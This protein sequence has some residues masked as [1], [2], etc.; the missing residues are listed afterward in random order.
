M[1]I[2]NPPYPEPVRPR[3]CRRPEPQSH[4][5]PE[6]PRP[7]HPSRRRTHRTRPST[8]AKRNP[9]YPPLVCQRLTVGQKA[10]GQDTN[11][12]AHQLLH[13]TFTAFPPIYSAD[14]RYC[15]NYRVRLQAPSLP[16]TED[17]CP[18][19]GADKATKTDEAGHKTAAPFREFQC[20]PQM[21]LRTAR[22]SEG[23]LRSNGV[24]ARKDP[25]RFCVFRD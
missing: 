16:G 8:S 9:R 5:P 25:R 4:R 6:T 18:P 1:S 2:Q 23:G 19:C 7:L 20:R 15:I 11:R 24:A 14:G 22:G 21:R 3:G 13:R 17:F 10:D 12:R